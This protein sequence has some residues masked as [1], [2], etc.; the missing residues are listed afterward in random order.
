M[1]SRQDFEAI[2]GEFFSP[3]YSY[4]AMCF[5]GAGAED[6]CQQVFLKLW[7][8]MD[9]RGA[10][11]NPR[12]WL[13]RVAVN[14]K[15]DHLR[16][17]YSACEVCDISAVPEI[18]D[19]QDMA[20]DLIIGEAISRLGDDDRDILRLRAAGLSGDEIAE[21]LEIPPS[22]ARSR[23]ARAKDRLTQILTEWGY[24]V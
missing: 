12:A 15:N 20:E 16:K 22:T 5:G 13:F 17:K 1:A 9:S 3:V 23:I 7:E 2:Y 19:V 11:E 10:P 18:A 4:L 21:S 24:D 8:R 6:L 14:V